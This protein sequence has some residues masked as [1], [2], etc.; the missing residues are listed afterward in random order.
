ME[1]FEYPLINMAYLPLNRY[2]PHIGHDC[3]PVPVTGR[4]CF[5]EAGTY[6]CIHHNRLELIYGM[7]FATAHA[8]V[9]RDELFYFLSHTFSPVPGPDS[10]LDL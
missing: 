2:L 1:T 7:H 6:L 8:P 4:F 9:R 3:E 5:S 10:A